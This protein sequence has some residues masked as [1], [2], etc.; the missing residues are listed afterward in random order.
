MNKLEF[1][2]NAILK[3]GTHI[4]QFNKDGIETRFKLVKDNFDNLVYFNLTNHKGKLFTVDLVNGL[5]GYNYLPLSY[6][7]SKQGKKNIRLIFFRRNTIKI[8][9]NDLKTKSHIIT[10]HLGFQW[11]NSNNENRRII[12]EINSEGNFIIKGK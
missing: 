5:I 7:E 8:G 11:L 12:L 4:H 10:Y 2:W 3:D 9:M 1:T 6:I